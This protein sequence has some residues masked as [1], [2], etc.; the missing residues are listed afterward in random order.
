MTSNAL[1]CSPKSVAVIG[2]DPLG[3]VPSVIQDANPI[4]M[5]SADSYAVDNEGMGLELEDVN[6]FKTNMTSPEKNL[7]G[8]DKN[9]YTAA[10]GNYPAD[11]TNGLRQ[12]LLEP[13]RTNSRYY[14]ADPWN[15][16]TVVGTFSLSEVTD[17]TPFPGQSVA[18]FSENSSSGTQR[19]IT[20]AGGTISAGVD[21][22]VSVIARCLDVGEKRYLCFRGFGS[23]SGTQYPVFDLE[24]G[25]VTRAGSTDWSNTGIVELGDG[26]WL[27]YSN[28]NASAGGGSLVIH[29]SEDSNPSGAPTYNGD[30][31]SGMYFYGWQVEAADYHTS[32][33]RTT[34]ENTASRSADN[35]ELTT[36]VRNILDTGNRAIVICGTR[37]NEATGQT[38]FNLSNNGTGN[39][40]ELLWTNG[41]QARMFVATSSV[42]QADLFSTN[43]VAEGEKWAIAM[44]WEDNDFALSL[45]GDGPATDVAGTVPTTITNAWLNRRHDADPNQESEWITAF[46]VFETLTDTQMQ[47]ITLELS[48]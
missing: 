35:A 39:R 48:S 1:A 19:S 30:G 27:C 10:S 15:E 40:I 21:Y 46:A 32:F 29:L 23:G 20:V 5:F 14:S 34:G 43:T 4:L 26:F 24:T 2:G 42:T 47:D 6:D 12:L 37:H 36:A 28:V 44:R 17:H 25:T 7:I 11:Y 13:S 45:N 38:V 22:A 16:A 18:E 31:E 41:N 8:I 3:W 9:L 33:M